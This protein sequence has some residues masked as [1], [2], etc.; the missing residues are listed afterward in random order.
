MVTDPARRDLVEAAQ[1]I[2]QRAPQTASRWYGGMT[3][4]ILS[5]DEMPA[6]FAYAREN[7]RYDRELRQ[8]VFKAYR[9]IFTII[10]GG[11][12][13]LRVVHTAQDEI[14]LEGD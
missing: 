1:F 2:A 8:N 14:D 3:E 11:V 9:V 10:D 5:L 6:R 12:Y 7:D 13:V 4:A